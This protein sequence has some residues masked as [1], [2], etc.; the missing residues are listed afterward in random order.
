MFHKHTLVFADQTMFL[1]I[2]IRIQ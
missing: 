2:D 1:K